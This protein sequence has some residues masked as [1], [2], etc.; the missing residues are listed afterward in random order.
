MSLFAI[1]DVFDALSSDRHYRKDW[2]MIETIAHIKEQSGKHF[3]SAMVD[4][5]LS[6]L[7]NS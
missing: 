3:G 4:A 2:S 6:L 5:F 1:V 7:K